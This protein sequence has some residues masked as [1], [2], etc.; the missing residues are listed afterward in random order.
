M[1]HENA[2]SAIRAPGRVR[3]IL[4]ALVTLVSFLSS[5]FY[6]TQWALAKPDAPSYY[7]HRPHV[8]HRAR[9][10]YSLLQHWL[11]TAPLTHSVNITQMLLD[12]PGRWGMFQ[13]PI[14]ELLE[15]APPETHT[16]E[17]HSGFGP[18]LFL[19]IFSIAKEYH[20]RAVIRALQTPLLPPSERVVMK[21]ILGRSPDEKLQ[22]MAETE[23][24]MYEDMVFLDIEENMNGGKT[25]AYFKWVAG[26][27]EGERPRFTLKSDSDTFLVLPAVLHTLAHVSCAQLVYW[28]TSWGSCLSCYPF[29]HR[30]MGYGLSWPLVAWLGSASLPEWAT[31]GIE[32][33]RTGAWLANLPP[34]GRGQAG[35]PEPLTVVDMYYH[36]GNWDGTTIPWDRD[37]V[38]LHSMK[39]PENYVRVAS[40]LKQMWKEQWKEWRWPPE[41][42]VQLPV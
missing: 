4:F 27:P 35:Q 34:V 12:S 14:P 18:M 8:P 37:T 20:Q 13:E 6:A 2:L 26:M 21:F 41:G 17:D 36:A 3:P 23:A 9:P 25:Y 24:E 22:K 16:C 11:D 10:K 40:L 15:A 39:Q 29:Y 5:A 28:G 31:Q 1:F 33:M 30:G 19:G 32:D 7:P 42:M 38:A